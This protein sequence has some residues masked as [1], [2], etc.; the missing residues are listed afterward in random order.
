MN[1]PEND[2]KFYLFQELNSHLIVVNKGTVILGLFSSNLYQKTCFREIVVCLPSV[3]KV[4]CLT[5][6]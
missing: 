5:F 6:V 2:L 1:L 3:I 4:I